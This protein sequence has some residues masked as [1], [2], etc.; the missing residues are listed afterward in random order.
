MTEKL[1]FT[2]AAIS[3]LPV[4]DFS[5][6][7]YRDANTRGLAL[8]VSPSGERVFYLYRKVAGR[9]VKVALG[10]FDSK[11]PASRE[12]PKGV[13]PLEYVG[14]R[15]VLNLKMA[16]VL[17]AAVGVELGRGSNP[18]TNRRG[19]RRSAAAE[20]SLRE[21]FE[22][23]YDSH[24][25]PSGRR[26]RE[27]LR[28]DF[29]RY[30]GRVE[31]GP[32][33]P[34]GREKSKPT[35]CPN[36]ERRKLSAIR[37]A[38]IERLMLEMRRDISA[39][40]ANKALELLRAIYRRAPKSGRYAGPNICD[41]IKKFP[42]KSRDRFIQGPEL[43]RFWKALSAYPGAEP[44][45]FFML[46]LLT[47]ARRSNVTEM[48]WSQVDLERGE[49][50]IPDTKNGT[51]QIVPLP[52][53]A[54]AV[55]RARRPDNAAGFVLPGKGKAGH[56]VEPKGAWRRILRQA[57]LEGVLD[58][59]AAVAGWS[60]DDRQQELDA[61]PESLPLR[62]A[63]FI[64]KA[65]RR[66][67]DWSAIDMQDLR[68]HDLRRTM[69][70]WQVRQGASLAIVGKSLNHKSP[71]ATAIYARLEV[72]PVRDSMQRAASAMFAAA[73]MPSPTPTAEV[74]PIRATK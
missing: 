71:Q 3:A 35:C 20:L 5:R 13:D 8:R 52:E 51:P 15:P 45:D 4:P 9:P 74:I 58:L 53:Q 2:P 33:V 27:E 60:A 24:L 25:L 44:R 23:Y 59:L 16:R 62:L 50:R 64:A 41:G 32:R 14:N 18:A 28:G 67:L 46:A 48:C 1:R 65:K 47:G 43:P 63:Y 11:L 73:G 56:L 21:G 66:K 49:W 42:L 22:W 72:D 68:I 69:G 12:I 54:I 70:S 6:V 34:H 31:P 7:F 57:T 61:A 26:T 10:V 39:R 29:A 36:W 55:L 30:L 37:T 19:A 38:E 17:A 40:T